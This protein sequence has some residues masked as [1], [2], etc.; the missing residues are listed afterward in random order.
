MN[1]DGY[2]RL[3][4]YS[5]IS[6]N[7]SKLNAEL[8]AGRMTSE[9]KEKIRN[10]RLHTGTGKSYEKTHGRHT[11]RIVAERMLG[12]PLR[13]GEVVHHINGNKRDNRECNLLIFSSQA[14]H[15]RFHAEKGVIG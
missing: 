12:R 9:V 14:E 1:P 5:N 13:P 7:M 3:K 10:S 11:H 15:A 8:N 4:D 6:T 2:K